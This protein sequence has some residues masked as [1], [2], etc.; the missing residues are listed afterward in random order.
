MGCLQRRI[1]VLAI[2]AALLHGMAGSG[3]ERAAEVH[4]PALQATSFAEQTVKLPEVLQGKVGVLVLGFTHAS[5]DAVTGWGKRL[6]VD[7]HDSP[8]VQYFE[9]PV[10][11]AVPKMVRGM[12]IGK[13]KGSVPEPAKA[14]FVPILEN[15][16][17]WRAVASYKSGDDAYVLLV[18]G[19]GVVQ[20]QTHDAVS[21]A[22]YG[23]LKEQ[24][25]RLRSTIGQSNK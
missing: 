3:Q 12:V 11:A 5:Q 23:R 24:I 25:E 16:A 7:Y 18:D 8:D 21:D 19:Q 4:V 22:A 6:G 2:A 20:W 1:K 17:G 14:H 9:M 13:I 15:E 10:L